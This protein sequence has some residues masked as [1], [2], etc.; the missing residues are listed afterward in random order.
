MGYYKFLF[1]SKFIYIFVSE[2]C[3]KYKLKDLLKQVFR[4][5]ITYFNNGNK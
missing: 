3:C 4:L 2:I 1:I 5:F